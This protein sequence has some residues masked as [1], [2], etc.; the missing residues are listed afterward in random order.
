MH[1][2]Q[3]LEIYVAWHPSFE[4]GMDHAKRLFSIFCRDYKKPFDTTL[5]IPTYF[6]Y[7]GED[8]IPAPIE[9]GNVS[10]CAI[11]LL[12]D[13]NIIIDKKFRTYVDRLVQVEK[14]SSGNHRIFPI[15]F[16]KSFNNL[17][18]F[19]SSK[20]VIRAYDDRL[21]STLACS[22]DDLIKS[23]LLH[24]VSR[25]MLQLEAVQ[26]ESLLG[27]PPPIRLFLSHSKHDSTQ[28]SA[29]EFK[30]F[31]HDR[32]QLKTFFD[33]HDIGYG[34]DFADEIKKGIRESVLVV[35]QSDSYASRE[36]CRIEAITAKAHNCPVIVV[37]A[38]EKGEKRSFPYLGNVPTIRLGG[39]NFH[40][41]VD[42]ALEKVL[43][44]VYQKALMTQMA[45]LYNLD[46]N[47]TMANFPELFDIIN[48]QNQMKE[49]KR[50]F[51][52][53]LYPDPPLGSEELKLLNDMNDNLFFIT[54]NQLPTLEIISNGR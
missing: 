28:N 51:S 33:V 20:N 15:A 9:T 14:D 10:K 34:Y 36:W 47:Y 4:E 49:G 40:E 22:Q 41:I 5:S 12:I 29:M 52:I 44:N 31:I 18:E 54:P 38:L 27:A 30:R 25:L 42:M 23:A 32:T 35:F 19:I 48:I 24:E 17:H 6:R 1:F 13:D 16:T 8:N 45:N 7:L 46:V 37:N 11:V 43:Y 2:E 50:D 39:S 21:L 26:A 53:V 3:P